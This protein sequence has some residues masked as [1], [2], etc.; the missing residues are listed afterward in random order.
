MCMSGMHI[1]QVEIDLAYNEED[2]TAPK[3]RGYTYYG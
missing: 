2:V 1:P 3:V